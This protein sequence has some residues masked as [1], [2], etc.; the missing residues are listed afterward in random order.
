MAWVAINKYNI[1][2][3][4][5]NRPEEFMGLWYPYSIND[6][7]IVLPKGTIKKILGR[8]LTWGEDPVE[9]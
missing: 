3:I 1:E 8:E 4:F 5:D 9:I 7:F 6:N 2:F